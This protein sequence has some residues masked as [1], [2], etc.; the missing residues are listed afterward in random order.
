MAQ[1]SFGAKVGTTAMQKAAVGSLLQSNT[2]YNRDADGNYLS[3]GD[4]QRAM[5][6]D[7]AQLVN[8]GLMTSAEAARI[9]KSNGARS[10]RAGVGFGREQ[11]TIE[12]VA[13]RLRNGV[14]APD[15]LITP[16]EME[17]L[18]T[19]VLTGTGAAPLAAQ[20]HEST[21]ILG[22]E[23]RGRIETRL[24]ALRAARAS[25]SATAVTNAQNEVIAEIARGAAAMHDVPMPAMNRRNLVERLYGRELDFSGLTGAVMT[26]DASGAVVPLSFAGPMTVERAMEAVRGTT[27]F[28]ENKR[29]YGSAWAAGAAGA[30]P[31]PPGGP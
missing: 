16:D 4:M 20:R 31:T 15:Q 29:E 11:A 21:G 27:A 26:R 30:A 12:Q 5:T 9:V 6:T 19:D 18:S 14:R 3:F 8:Q 28:T 17:V 1:S 7:V 25:G 2:S 22:D 24:T 23:M 10:D 13:Q